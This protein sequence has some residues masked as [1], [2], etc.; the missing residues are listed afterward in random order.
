MVALMDKPWYQRFFPVI[1]RKPHP[2]STAIRAEAG[3]AD[4]Q[5][6]V[7]LKYAGGE[8]LAEWN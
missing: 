1:A 3:E 4:A 6:S 5:F 7:G 8:E 2:I